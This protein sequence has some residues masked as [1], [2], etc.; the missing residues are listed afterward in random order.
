LD[1][2]E[3]YIGNQNIMNR[4]LDLF[5]NKLK[6]YE[7]LNN[8]LLEGVYFYNFNIYPEETQPSGTYTFSDVLRNL[9]KINLN[10]SF[11]NEYFDTSD[12]SINKNSHKLE[13]NIILK[14]YNILMFENQSNYLVFNDK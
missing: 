13:L 12:N 9:I 6:S 4:D 1:D 11:L 5:Y 7:Y 14:N 3:F 10:S 2:L 8:S